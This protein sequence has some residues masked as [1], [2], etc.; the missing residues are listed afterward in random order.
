MGN[1]S[2]QGKKGK[3]KEKNIFDSNDEAKKT[4]QIRGGKQEK[5]IQ[6]K[7]RR[8]RTATLPLGKKEVIKDSSCK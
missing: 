6:K 3:G 7:G 5:K 4:K 1:W 8:L 2:L